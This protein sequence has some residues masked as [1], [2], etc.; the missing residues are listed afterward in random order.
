MNPENKYFLIQIQTLIEGAMS[1]MI[2]TD[3]T[4]PAGIINGMAGLHSEITK[5]LEQDK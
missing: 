4:I 2:D 5:F 1:N 3:E